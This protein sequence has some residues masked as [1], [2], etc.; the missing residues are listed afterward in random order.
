MQ[1]LRS[2]T[3]CP[4]CRARRCAGFRWFFFVLVLMASPWAGA[5]AAPKDRGLRDLAAIRQAP[6]TVVTLRSRERLL[7][8]PEVVGDAGGREPAGDCAG[9]AGVFGAD[10]LLWLHSLRG[11]VA[12]QRPQG[13]APV[14]GGSGT[15]GKALSHGWVEDSQ[16]LAGARAVD[17]AC[18][19][20]AG[21]VESPVLR[22]RRMEVVS[23]PH[24]YLAQLL[25]LIAAGRSMHLGC[26]QSP[27]G[28]KGPF[29]S[30]QEP[31]KKGGDG[32]PAA[33]AESTPAT[34]AA[35]AGW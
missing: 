12:A 19:D 6:V 21:S 20:A 24:D 35:S 2:S 32:S 13:H 10:P 3:S 34:T 8:L 27:G 22:L 23:S 18:A 11:L 16:P 14:S 17:S 33:A 9:P 15:L 28:A 7:A 1:P 29:D 25:G 5:D 4:P 30:D 26:W 31:K